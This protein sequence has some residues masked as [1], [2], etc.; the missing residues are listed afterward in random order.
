[1]AAVKQNGSD[2]AVLKFDHRFPTG[3][4]A[5]L[6]VVGVIAADVNSLTIGREGRKLDPLRILRPAPGV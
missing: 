3:P 2:N 4:S 1:M 6:L 5:E